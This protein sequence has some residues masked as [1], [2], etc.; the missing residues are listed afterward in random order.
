MKAEIITIGEE[1]LSGQTIDTNSA[2]IGGRLADIGI[3]VVWKTSIGDRLED[4]KTAIRSAWQRSQVTIVTGGLGPTA[5]DITKKAICVAFE[6]KL[7]FHD[8]ILQEIETRYRQRGTKMPALVQ[9]QALQPQGAEFIAN[10]IGSAVGILFRENDRYLVSLPGVPAE[11]KSMLDNGVI[12]QLEKLRRHDYIEVRKIRTI[13]IMEATIAEMVGDLQPDSENLR[14]AYL[15]SYRGVDLRITGK[16]AD[17]ALAR[18]EVERLTAAII[19]RLGEHV[20]T[21]GEESLTE[22]VNGLLILRRQTVATAESCTGGLMAKMITDISGS[23]GSFVGSVIAYA[24]EVKRKILK[25]PVSLL[26]SVGAVS[27]EVAEAMA[28]GVKKLTGA[29]FGLSTTGIA[30]PTGG[31]AEKPVG[32]VYIG[33]ADSN[34]TTVRKLNLSGTRERIREAACYTALDMLR[35]RLM[36]GT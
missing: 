30:G 24:N 1:I 21:Q 15:P 34:G 18:R 6:R 20:F 4:I 9:N 3:E 16:Y 36:G 29:D 25:V 14:L 2:Y 11:M 5:D 23:S 31:T 7:V 17:A 22:V 19:N 32:L 35:R 13:G 8:E 10:K 28:A 33:L 26:D 27:P 12:P